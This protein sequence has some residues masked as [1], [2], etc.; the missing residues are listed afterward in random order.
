VTEGGRFA[1]RSAPAIATGQVW[2]C[3]RTGR[4]R[5]KGNR[6]YVT[7]VRVVAIEMSEP[8]VIVHANVKRPRVLRRSD[9]N[10]FLNA[11]RFTPLGLSH[12]RANWI[13]EDTA[14]LT[15]EGEPTGYRG[16]G[17]PPKGLGHLPPAPKKLKPPPP[18]KP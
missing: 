7:A 13:D 2:V 1:R 17:R 12:P 15:F 4:N 6:H 5:L 8:P 11:F 16:R 9:I 18:E 3:N 14:P 10:E